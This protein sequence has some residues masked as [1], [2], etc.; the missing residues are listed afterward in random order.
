MFYKKKYNQLL[1]FAL[2]FKY[3]LGLIQ[4]QLRQWSQLDHLQMVPARPSPNF[5]KHHTY[6]SIKYSYMAFQIIRFPNKNNKRTF[7]TKTDGDFIQQKYQKTRGEA[8]IQQ[9]SVFFHL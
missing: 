7:V 4:C 9:I 5:F 8:V 6:M 1:Y 2:Y 3:F